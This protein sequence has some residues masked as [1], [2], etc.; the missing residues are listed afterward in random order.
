M[1]YLSIDIGGT[2][3]LIACMS[4]K[5]RLSRRDK[6]PTPNSLRDF[7]NTLYTHLKPY[8]E[9]NPSCVVVA[10]P[11]IVKNNTPVS[12]GNRPSW[13]ALHFA[14]VIERLFD[15]PI[16]F[17][18]DASL[19]TV[20]ES[21]FYSGKTIYLTFSTGIGGG[22][23]ERT[24]LIQP[25]TS[26]FEPGHRLYKYQGQKLEWEDIAS[27]KALEARFGVKATSI[28]GKDKYQ[29][30]AERIAIGLTDIIKAEKPNTIV[31]GGP[32]ALRFRHFIKPLKK[33]L[34]EDTGIQKLPRIRPAKSPK[35]AVT[36]GM[37]IYAK[38]QDLDEDS[39]GAE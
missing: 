20:Y 22:I 33:L 17:E 36:H 27:C 37:H 32:L 24:K 28:R 3:T 38:Q 1:N 35:E 39:N 34:K 23:A 14:N 13:K 19:G 31:I 5:G 6:F 7:L 18:N 2:K 11:G 12:L 25:D 10:V 26:H 16:Y 4:E 9:T 15:C 29:E 8:Q 30:I 21:K